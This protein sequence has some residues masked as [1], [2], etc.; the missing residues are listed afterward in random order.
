MQE[1][2]PEEEAFKPRPEA[3]VMWDGE[4]GGRAS[5]TKLHVTGP[6]MGT[7]FLYSEEKTEVGVT[8]QG[9]ASE[10]CP[11]TSSVTRL[12]HLPVLKA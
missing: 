5:E 1:G 7:S 2:D 11:W 3:G 6:V 8:A 4:K 12:L 10:V 9:R